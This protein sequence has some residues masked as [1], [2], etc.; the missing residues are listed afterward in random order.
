MLLGEV[1]VED[2]SCLRSN[3]T[4]LEGLSGE[5]QLITSLSPDLLALMSEASIPPG[6]MRS[7]ELLSRSIW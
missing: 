7:I 2:L 1:K 5:E 6:P 4:N 3:V